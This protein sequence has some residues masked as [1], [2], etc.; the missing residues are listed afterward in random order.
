MT[1]GAGTAGTAALD[2]VLPGL[3]APVRPVDIRETRATVDPQRFAWLMAQ[4]GLILA[5]FHLYALEEAA[6]LI[7]A[8]MLVAGF[9]IHYWLPFAWKEPFWIGWSLAGAFVMLEPFAALLLIVA[10]LTIYG[11]V[12]MP[13]A[14]RWRLAALVV[15]AAFAIHG[16]ATHGYGIPYQFWPVFGAI[17]M[18]RLLVYLYDVAHAKKR[19]ELR[20]FLS[21]FFL[22]PNYYF[23]LFPVVDY[24]TLRQSYF[25]RD[26]HQV[27]QQGIVWIGRGTIQLLL[28]RLIYHWKGP[29][30]APE[31][32]SS[33]GALAST[34]VL[35]YLLYLRVSGQFHLIVG[36]LR[37]F[38]YDLPETHRRYLLANSLTDFWR[39]INI[40]WKD[41]MVKLV[42]FPLYFRLRR[43]GEVRAQVVATAMV[44]VTTWFL[45]AYQWFWLRGEFAITAQDT[46]FW[47]ILGCLVTVNLL[48]E[49]R[50]QPR[51]PVAG[52][53]MQA[54]GAVK[55]AATFC[56]IVTLW[57]LWNSPSPAEWLDLV[58]WWKLG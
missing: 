34:M 16:R 31:S 58:T 30:N 12:A 47:A 35:T 5:V 2:A 55:V 1:P 56:L 4:L 17:F 26:I 9:A 7:L 38:G 48:L 33:F 37:L 42:Y 28:Y 50:K 54:I 23:L 41:F 10:G 39:R 45:H 46:L 6:F 18:F 11:I 43:S 53:R 40:Y 24:Q 14:F 3:A 52:W 22:L 49:R 21:Y 19:P 51:R 44:F 36:F 57:S 8:W 29:S 25:R 15:L 32:V 13:I 20:D 27:A